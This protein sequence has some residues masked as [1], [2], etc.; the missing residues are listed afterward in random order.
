MTASRYGNAEEDGAGVFDRD[1]LAGLIIEASRLLETD[2]CKAKQCIQR[3]AELVRGK[4]GFEC[5]E[6]RQPGVRGGLCGWQV[7]LVR[8]YIE[9]NLG[10][11]IAIAELAAQVH[12]SIGHFS[13]TFRAS[14]GASPQ[15]YIRRQRILRAE[16]LMRS[17]NEPLARIAVDCGLCDQPHFSRTFRRIFGVTPNAWR[18]QVGLGQQRAAGPAGPMFSA[19]NHVGVM[20]TK[21]R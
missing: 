2:R 4:Q 15:A 1:V 18:R 17:S 7:R 20:A 19:P 12:L 9:S 14:F 21:A 5:L 8:A 3:A 16:A 13:R 10:G 6:R 11:R